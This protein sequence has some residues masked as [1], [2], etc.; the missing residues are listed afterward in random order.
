MICAGASCFAAC[1]PAPRNFD[2]SRAFQHLLTQ[3]SFGPRVPGSE[4]HRRTHEWMRSHLEMHADR[5]TDHTFQA[6]SPINSTT[7]ELRSLIAV[8]NEESSSRV[9]FGAHWDTRAFADEET[10]EALRKLPVPGANDG[11]SGVAI[12]LEIAS[13]LK[14][15]PPSIGVDL[16][17]FDGEDQG[18]H[19]DPRSWAL[20]SQRFVKDYPTYRPSFVVILDMVGREGTRILKEGNSMIAAA[21]L[22]DRVWEIGRSSGCTVL[23]DS[24][25]APV[26]DDHVPFLEAGIP[27]VD[28]IDLADPAW[29]TTRDLPEHCSELSLGE[30]GRLVQAIIRQAERDL[31]P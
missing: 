9:L 27:A 29:H 30:V 3:V 26:F 5:V 14:E 11:G 6:T 7:M 10:D 22:V 18:L 15:R 19:G 1:S 8:F 16:A 2:E 25:G 31:S 24:A 4:G 12:L 20:G 21:P 17:F 23:V 13:Q 28:L